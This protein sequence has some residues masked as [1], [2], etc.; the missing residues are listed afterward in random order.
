M[1]AMLLVP[2]L[3]VLGQQP[4]A[5]ENETVATYLESLSAQ[6]HL[7]GTVLIARGQNILFERSFG[8]AEYPD[9]EPNAPQTLFAVASV[10]KPLTGIAVRRLAAQGRL[11]LDDPIEKWLPDFPNASRITVSQLLGHRSGLPH[12]VSRPE[13]E[14]RPQ[15]AASMTA[16]ASK[17]SLVFEPGAQR[18]YSSAGYSVLARVI[19]RVTSKPYA[20]AMRELVFAPASVT[21]TVDATEPGV[22]S[23]PRARGHLWTPEG[24]LPAPRKDLSYLVGAGSLWATPRDLFRLIRSVVAGDFAGV[25]GGAQTTEGA[26]RWSGWSNGFVAVVDYAP[27]TDTTLIYTGNVLTGAGDWLVRDLPRL[28]AGQTVSTARPPSPSSF[29][30][31]VQRR[32]QL[33]GIYRYVG[34]EQRLSFLSPSVA[35]LGDEYPFVATGP[36]TLFAPLNY[37][38]YTVLSDSAGVVMGLQHTGDSNIRIMRAPVR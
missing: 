34:A 19:E 25:A 17:A 23:R 15:T 31:S 11:G 10:T 1:R 18:L 32:Q 21:T 22:A 37:A 7:S 14:Q 28:L 4:R 24:P 8:R 3:I 5:G 38:E 29:H 27:A 33:E 9:R 20:Q 36:S 26:I 16:L 13:D 30:L 35:L 2:A 12:R 6:G